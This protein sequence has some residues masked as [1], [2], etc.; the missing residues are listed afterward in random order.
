[1]NNNK[2]MLRIRFK[3]VTSIIMF[4]HCIACF[5]VAIQL[6][7]GKPSVFY[8]GPHLSILSP[9]RGSIYHKN[10]QLSVSVDLG[11]GVKTE[12][13]RSNLEGFV[14]CCSGGMEVECQPLLGG[15]AMR[16]IEVRAPLNGV[17]EIRGWL[18]A[19]DAPKEWGSQFGL[20]DVVYTW[21]SANHAVAAL[22]KLAGSA[23]LLASS[24]SSPPLPSSSSP[25]SLSSSSPTRG[26]GRGG[27]SCVRAQRAYSHA[28]LNYHLGLAL[29]RADDT[30]AAAAGHEEEANNSNGNGKNHNGGGGGGGGSFVI[31]ANSLTEA[32]AAL[33]AAASLGIGEA[34]GALEEVLW[35]SGPQ[36]SGPMPL[37][38][39]SY[40]GELDLGF[41]EKGSSSVDSSS[42]VSTSSVI[43]AWLMAY[44]SW[45]DVREF[46]RE[47]LEN[48]VCATPP[49]VGATT[50]NVGVHADGGGVNAD[51]VEKEEEAETWRRIECVERGL[52]AGRA[53]V[54]LK[55]GDLSDLGTVVA[56]NKLVPSDINQHL[57][58]LEE[59]ASEVRR[60][61]PPH[62]NLIY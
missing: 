49:E 18:Q 33:A 41:I 51:D 3:K 56:A 30:A 47:V 17:A 55:C 58:V 15:T 7:Y 16:V 38:P 23:A 10:V 25:V 28:M 54:A 29:M 44:Q 48:F 26:G 20:G 53:A 50:I 22:R 40:N 5:I 12:E 31:E 52:V 27:D 57:D 39:C 42:S 46:L 1:M 45:G 9:A 2:N 4:S 43:T 8:D 24:S 13:I 14:V 6:S 59:L 36:R 19:T 61:S 62:S 21:N 34:V 60:E 37:I 35:L 11:H 32:A